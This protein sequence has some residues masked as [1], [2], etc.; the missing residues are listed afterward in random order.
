M[1]T[2]TNII[3]FGETGSGKS[4]IVNM[5]SA[6]ERVA[7]ISSGAKGCTFKSHPF[8][9]DILGQPMTIWDTAGLDEGDAGS[10]S[11]SDAIIELY[12]LVRNLSDGVSLLMFV[13]RAP[14]IKS[15]V[16]QNWKFFQEIICQKKVPI[17]IAITGLEQEENM[18]QWWWD[19]KGTFQGYG[20][21]PVG[22]AC[23]TASRGKVHKRGG[24][25][26]DGEY[27]ESQKKVRGL[28]RSTALVTPWRVPAAEWF[29]NIVYT[30][31]EYESNGWC[32][33]KEVRRDHTKEVA[34]EALQKLVGVYGMLDSDAAEMA[35][36]MRSL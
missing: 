33:S 4:S 25:V 23:I 34:G 19:N 22:F 16:P 12:K 17:V 28:I 11:K 32:G 27:E 20:I 7:D 8:D 13:M 18:D 30:T 2:G 26:F 36:K 5:L 31:V 21:S 6:N 1:P 35:G 14:R 15:S 24:Y 10:V 9:I 29:K 3:L